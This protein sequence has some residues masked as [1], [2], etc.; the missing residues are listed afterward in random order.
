MQRQLQLLEGQDTGMSA[1]PLAPSPADLAAL[2]IS[3]SPAPGVVSGGALLPHASSGA[4]A[5]PRGM[6]ALPVS[7]T[8][9]SSGAA[10]AAAAAAVSATPYVASTAPEA[11]KPV[12][13][14]RG[15][16]VVVVV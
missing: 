9:Y 8:G 12:K 7:E 14:V 16:V 3:H 15:V 1:S 13:R 10:A 6:A 5:L 11:S 4:T 2:T